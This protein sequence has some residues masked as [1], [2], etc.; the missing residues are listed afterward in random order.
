MR[1]GLRP[2]VEGLNRIVGAVLPQARIERTNA[3]S[4]AELA[5]AFPEAAGLIV[6]LTFEVTDVV[7]AVADDLL[8]PAGLTRFIV[9]PRALRVNYP[10]EALTRPESLEGK[11]EALYAWIQD[12]LAARK[13]RYYAE[14]TYLFDE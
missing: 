6:F 5:G 12:R 4:L 3:R 14:A 8:L 2:R 13:I 1:R 7:E 10:L 11:A 9:S